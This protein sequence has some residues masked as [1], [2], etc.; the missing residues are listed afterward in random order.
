MTDL[1][2][3]ALDRLR[4]LDAAIAPHSNR[5]DRAIILI[6]ECLAEG[7]DR[8][9]DIIQTLTDLGF[10]QRHVGKLISDGCGP[11]PERHHWQ[12]MP[13]GRYRSHGVR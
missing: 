5:H 6:K 11:K 3:D 13:D 4:A 1:T 7:I 8:G 12:K 9:T 2:T 10:D